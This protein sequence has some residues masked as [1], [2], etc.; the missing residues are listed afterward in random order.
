MAIGMGAG[1]GG[2]RSA[3]ASS[4]QALLDLSGFYSRAQWARFLHVSTPAMSQW[5]NDRTLP[6]ADLLG[7]LVDL[8]RVRGG[9]AA[10]EHLERFDEMAARDSGDVS[11]F[12]ARMAPTVAAYIGE[13]SLATLGRS[14]RGLGPAERQQALSGSWR[15]GGGGVTVQAAPRSRTATGNRGPHAC[16]PAAE[17]PGVDR[18]MLPRVARVLAD[19][20]E[21]PC[22]SEATVLE[23]ARALLV[24][25]P[26][27]GKTSILL[28]LGETYFASSGSRPRMVTGLDFDGDRFPESGWAGDPAAGSLAGRLVFIDGFDEVPAAERGRAVEAIARMSATPGLRL[29]VASR[30]VPELSM[31]EGFERFSLGRL[32]QMQLV[33]AVMR[34]LDEPPGPAFPLVEASRFLCHFSERESLQKTLRHPLFLECAWRLFRDRA[35]T[36]F[37]ETHI[38]EGCVRGLFEHGDGAA[39]SRRREPWA[40]TETLSELSGEV[41]YKSLLSETPVFSAHDVTNWIGPKHPAMD[42]RRLAWALA[43]QGMLRGGEDAFAF[44]EEVVRDYLAAMH[45]V[46]GCDGAL[47][48]LGE[49]KTRADLRRVLRMAC[50][51]TTDATALLHGILAAV[52]VQDPIR[53][54]LL[55]DILAQPIAADPGTLAECCFMLVEWLDGELADWSVCQAA[56]PESP[57]TEHLWRLAAT[58]RP[59][60]EARRAVRAALSAVHRARSGPTRDVLRDRF[61]AARS[62]VLPAFAE[63]MDVEGKLDLRFAADRTGEGM[64]ALVSDLKLN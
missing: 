5:V 54:A 36:P 32:S 11:P 50:G 14:M 18:D 28:T 64:T 23:P 56:E 46:K 9:A 44:S 42:G 63:C 4:L 51:I 1:S 47:A 13:A 35:V 6:R 40:S 52:E 41:S 30:P 26:G 2:P 60:G 27:A 49:W 31:L 16:P 7:M 12:G 58:G 8:L 25:G 10:L 15:R 39:P 20:N 33:R 3:F 53:F 59:I 57:E 34:S 24:A 29:V 43:E 21:Q 17:A 45:V 61:G 55:A 62:S 37:A 22:D 19:G 38:L 48:Y